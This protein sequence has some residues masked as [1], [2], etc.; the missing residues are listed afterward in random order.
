MEIAYSRAH[1]EMLASVYWSLFRDFEDSEDPDQQMLERIWELWRWRLDVLEG[2]GDAS[3][4][5]EEAGGLLWFV[6]LKRT[7]AA[8]AVSLGVRTLSL[9]GTATAVVH[10][11]WTRLGPIADAEPSGALSLV[12]ALLRTEAKNPYRHLDYADAALLCRSIRGRVPDAEWQVF[13]TEVDNL[14]RKGWTA[15][16]QLVE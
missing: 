3:G 15:L 2:R 12:S 1:P 9:I 8:L 14:A 5:N 11:V 13:T 4:S 16:R 10:S 7:P 6:V